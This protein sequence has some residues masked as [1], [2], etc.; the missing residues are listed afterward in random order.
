[1]K[2]SVGKAMGLVLFSSLIGV[3]DQLHVRFLSV[4][5]FGSSVEIT[6]QTFF[7]AMAAAVAY[8]VLHNRTWSFAR[9]ISNLLMTVPVATIADN[10]S[11]DAGTHTP[12]VVVIPREGFVWRE[13]VFGHTAGLSQIA[14]WMN[15][16]PLMQGLINGYIAA[17][18][19]AGSYVALQY[20][21]SRHNKASTVTFV[22][23]E[24]SG[25][26]AANP[27]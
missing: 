13:L 2:D 25:A 24:L 17:I 18:G 8:L 6:Y 5:Q 11:I 10:V 15:Q 12:Y 3:L 19:I 20:I 22:T 14:L 21:W 7:I 26:P 23:D 9:N 1:M 16:Q 4:V 27:V